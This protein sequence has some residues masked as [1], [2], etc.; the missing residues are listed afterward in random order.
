MKADQRQEK[1]CQLRWTSLPATKIRIPTTT[2]F[3]RLAS[4]PALD[5]E[6]R[7]PKAK[8]PAEPGPFKNRRS[9]RSLGLGRCL[10][11]RRGREL[12]VRAHVLDLDLHD[13][14]LVAF[15]LEGS[16]DQLADDHDTLA[17]LQAL[18]C[19]LGD[20]SPGR[21]AAAFHERSIGC[22]KHS[23]REDGEHM[24]GK[25]HWDIHHFSIANPKGSGDEGNF[26]ALLRRVAE[27][28]EKK[29]DIRVQ[30]VTFAHE[31]TEDGPWWS[32]TIYFH[33][34]NE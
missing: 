33:F 32:A 31:M 12:Q 23:K 11:D 1:S 15:D 28:M 26:P 25:T 27:S 2:V 16:L 17:F 6:N 18:R 19:V 21:A 9:L 22:Q 24:A 34:E 29:G 3:E 30:D 5:G 10:F 13:R 7:K 20:R 8:G 14:S 4:L